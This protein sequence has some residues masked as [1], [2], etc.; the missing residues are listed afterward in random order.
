MVADMRLFRPDSPFV[1]SPR[2]L[3]APGVDLRIVPL[4]CIEPRAPRRGRAKP[5]AG[6]RILPNPG[7]GGRVAGRSG[8]AAGWLAVRPPAR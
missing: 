5:L 4:A 1:L 2:G 3:D 8:R 6:E 7:P